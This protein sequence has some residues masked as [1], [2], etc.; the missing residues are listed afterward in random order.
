MTPTHCD[1]CGVST[2]TSSYDV[3]MAIMHPETRPQM[4]RILMSPVKKK[5]KR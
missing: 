4:D 2:G 3:H 5:K 1:L